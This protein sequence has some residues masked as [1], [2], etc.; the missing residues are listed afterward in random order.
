MSV[1]NHILLDEGSF[2]N[3]KSKEPS[4]DK[5][6]NIIY[7]F[8]KTT[9]VSSEIEKKNDRI[10]LNYNTS[11]TYPNLTIKDYIN[12]SAYNIT[13]TKLVHNIFP[14]ITE[15]NNVNPDYLDTDGNNKIIGEMFIKHRPTANTGNHLYLCFLLMKNNSSKH[16]NDIDK[17]IKMSQSNDSFQDIWI[18]NSIPKQIHEP[19]TAVTYDSK[20]NKIIVFLTPILINQNSANIISNLEPYNFEDQFL[21]TFDNLINDPSIAGDDNR[22]Y[23]LHQ[24]QHVNKNTSEDKIYIKCHPTGASA[25]EINTYNVPV[26]S[27]YTKQA[28]EIELKNTSLN[29]ILFTGILIIT[30]FVI[31]LAYFRMIYKGV[32]SVGNKDNMA[33]ASAVRNID[34][35]VILII[36]GAIFYLIYSGV[37]NAMSYVIYTIFGLGISMLLIITKKGSDPDWIQILDYDDVNIKNKFSGFA[38]QNFSDFIIL[39]ITMILFP[40]YNL[41]TNK[42]MVGVIAFWVVLLAI[43]YVF[44]L[45]INKETWTNTHIIYTV[46][47]IY[48]STFLLWSSGIN[49]QLS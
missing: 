49:Q 42:P 3:G 11:H 36:I 34:F 9:V 31:P 29:L 21:G 20:N 18:S 32:I 24:P 4:S 10:T 16:S 28:S 22:T 41:S 17:L 37:P 23:M 25:E 5:E 45:V 1:N 19:A 2:V 27:E 14:N 8:P 15:E 33:K 40:F 30:Y 13:I 48:G 26:E 35:S 38:P 47:I 12:Y 39:F 44:S 7:T 6:K 46:L 43:Y